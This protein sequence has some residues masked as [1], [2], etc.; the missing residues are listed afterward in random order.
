MAGS[1]HRARRGRP[2]FR[3]ARTQVWFPALRSGLRSQRC[4]SCGSGDVSSDLTP[5]QELPVPQGG[6][7]ESWWRNLQH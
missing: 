6:P 2:R 3:S 1:S 7:K 5:A 4:H